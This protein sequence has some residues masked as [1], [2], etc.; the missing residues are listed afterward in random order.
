[1]K[2]GKARGALSPNSDAMH[3]C[4]ENIT[5]MIDGDKHPCTCSCA[6]KLRCCK[7]GLYHSVPP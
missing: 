1:M 4:V 3:Q 7:V 6:V 5:S 2:S